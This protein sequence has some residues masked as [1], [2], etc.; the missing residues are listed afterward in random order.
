MKKRKKGEKLKKHTNGCCPKLGKLLNVG[1]QEPEKIKSKQEE[2]RCP[3]C[4]A[5]LVLRTAQKGPNVGKQFYGCKAFPK[6]KYIR[7]MEA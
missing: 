5:E 4:G 7:N 2:L 1:E 6:C 3:K